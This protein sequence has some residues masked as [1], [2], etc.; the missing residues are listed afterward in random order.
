MN[1]HIRT[2]LLS[3]ASL[4]TLAC[5]G[6][7]N[8]GPGGTSR[9]TVDHIV[10]STSAASVPVGQTVTL[11]ATPVAADGSTITGTSIS[12]SSGA[13]AIATVNAFGVVTGV[14]PGVADIAATSGGKS[15]HTAVTVTP[16]G[17]GP[18]G[19]YVNVSLDREL[20]TTCGWTALGV[21]RCWGH[22]PDGEVGDG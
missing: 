5:G 15:G 14:A 4:G 16:A 9:P 7:G 3:I 8:T 1:D 22:N 13:K 19:D 17:G 11:T 20:Y 2:A 21:A 18:T 10:M 12:W 6:S